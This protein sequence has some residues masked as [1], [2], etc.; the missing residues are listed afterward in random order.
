MPLDPLTVGS[1][2][3]VLGARFAGADVTAGGLL[4]NIATN[5]VHP[6][7]ESFRNQILSWFNGPH[8]D[9]NMD[10]ERAVAR[11][12]IHADLFCIIEALHE[13]LDPPKSAAAWMERLWERCPEGIR[14]L[15]PSFAG[16]FSAAEH[17]QLAQIK[18][19]CLRRLQEVESSTFQPLPPDAF[20][21]HL[22]RNENYQRQLTQAAVRA[23]EQDY[24]KLPEA[25][26]QIFGTKWFAY[27]C[28]SFSYEIKH[29]QP[30]SNIY[31][32]IAAD[33]LKRLVR[34]EGRKTRAQVTQE[35]QKTRAAL[36]GAVDSL[37]QEIRKLQSAE[38]V[39]DPAAQA[40]ELVRVLEEET[41]RILED[42]ESR[43]GRSFKTWR[44]FLDFF[45]PV[46]VSR[47]MLRPDDNGSQNGNQGTKLEWED[48]RKNL[49]RA[50]VLGN[51][52]FGKT[53]LLWYE[54][55]RRNQEWLQR[56]QNGSAAV[57]QADV[58]LFI[59]ALELASG[60][61]GSAGSEIMDVLMARVSSRI[62]LSPPVASLIREK[63]ARG[64]G[65]IAI[66]ALDETPEDLRA[67]LKTKLAD[68]SRKYP[69]ARLLLSSRWLGYSRAP[70]LAGAREELEVLPFSHEQMELAVKRWFVEDSRTAA[71]VWQ[72]IQSQQSICEEL[73]SPLLLRLA[74]AATDDKRR[75]NEKLLTWETRGELY[76]E[77]IGEAAHLW[78]QRT[79]VKEKASLREAEFL[80]PDCAAELALELWKT[81]PRRTLW[82]QAEVARHLHR[83]RM[84]ERSFH[85]RSDLLGDLC[86]AGILAL[87]GTEDR[88][89][90]VMFTHRSL[91]EYLAARALAGLLENGTTAEW[92]L[93]DRK[94]WDPE[95][96]EVL[97]LVT[98]QLTPEATERYLAVFANE[99]A[100]DEIRHRL[101]LAARCVAEIPASMRKRL[102]AL[103]DSITTSVFRFYEAAPIPAMFWYVDSFRRIAA[104]LNGAPAPP[105]H[106]LLA[107]VTRAFRALAPINGRVGSQSLSQAVVESST[108]KELIGIFGDAAPRLSL[109]SKLVELLHNPESSVRLNALGWLQE[110][111]PKASSHS[112]VIDAV[113]Q[114]LS[115]AN[116]QIQNEAAETLSTFDAAAANFPG[117][118]DMLLDLADQE[119]DEVAR[120]AE[121]AWIELVS[122]SS[123]LPAVVNSLLDLLQD[124]DYWVRY[125]AVDRLGG[126]AKREHSVARQFR[127]IN[128]LVELLHDPHRFVRDRTVSVLGYFGKAAIERREDVS[129]L[130]NRV[131]QSFRDQDADA[132]G[133]AVEVLRT[134]GVEAAR[135]AGVLD[136]LCG[137]LADPDEG[138]RLVAAGTLGTMGEAVAERPDIVERLM[139][140]LRST[141]PPARLC[142][143]EA[144]DENRA[145]L[146]GYPAVLESSVALLK[147]SEPEVRRRAATVLAKASGLLVQRTDLVLEM[148]RILAET[149]RMLEPN[150][151][152]D[153]FTSTVLANDSLCRLIGAVA[154]HPEVVAR[155]REQQHSPDNFIRHGVVQVLESLPEAIVSRP[156]VRLLLLNA[157]DDSDRLI[158]HKAVMICQSR[159]SALAWPE[160]TTRL[161]A[162][163][164]DTDID[165]LQ[166]V[167]KAFKNMGPALANSPEVIDGLAELLDRSRPDVKREVS[168]ILG[169]ISPT[170]A[171][172]RALA[173]RF[174]ALM[175][176][177]DG[178][179]RCAAVRATGTRGLAAD[180]PSLLHTLVDLLSDPEDGVSWA[181]AEVLWNVGPALGEHASVIERLMTLFDHASEELRLR[182]VHALGNL[183]SACEAAPALVPRL[184]TLL[185]DP[186]ES[187]RREALETL[188]L[189]PIPKSEERAA[190]DGLVELLHHSDED[191]REKAAEILGSMAEPVSR[192]QEFV[193][194]LFEQAADSDIEQTIASMDALA[195]LVDGGIRFWW[196]EDH[197]IVKTVRELSAE[198]PAIVD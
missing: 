35:H 143:L 133:K 168:V 134:I 62:S 96:E 86:S 42:A 188:S 192:Y 88:R 89:T 25:A 24:G 174:N 155:L 37:S 103:I 26:R 82:D 182:A 198:N 138:V 34:H 185:H 173:A 150:A 6:D 8:Y 121:A 48:A 104:T 115:D 50:V 141:E 156:D 139:D 167:L 28:N 126:I 45:V 195:A 58:A 52:G 129:V 68:F 51:P 98:G 1:I 117:L 21:L 92:A 163:A 9:K 46:R 47:G 184:V 142:A 116:P 151:G 187:V 63:L 112:E 118:L 100:D 148:L 4:A 54:A 157:M 107:H 147:D 29:N 158:K 191:I 106:A 102:A 122:V 175:R 176:D 136:E 131:A 81:D 91:G 49:Q 190:L 181:A 113:M 160:I 132:R 15:R 67:I 154:Q 12:S 166:M 14:N 7:V 78:R 193:S 10:L 152:S 13:P 159:G 79:E 125:S 144:L 169:N 56:M 170:G 33:R 94:A 61:E 127:I 95:W 110:M 172:R 197:H 153:R 109:T 120:A 27:L 38:P 177:A 93:I 57:G 59:R 119:D 20:R 60:L 40:Q 140:L 183:G 69:R 19:G 165:L 90:P 70:L 149:P 145:V 161:F 73:Q 77:F 114:L 16:I 135:H 11:S 111:G 43:I 18:S 179:V 84:R 39:V 130:A 105:T 75:R 41:A 162:L 178:T 71:L 124:P 76:A 137:L 17:A 72:H 85:Q 146:S 44:S 189:A 30:V 101:A 97:V 128:A 36:A 3:A 5:V 23:L 180:E 65:L 2:L 22:G 83:I 108:F 186:S 194:R 66:D 123:Q 64:E 171:R 53:T 74:C 87:A 55:G 31:Q 32:R 164:N 99:A 196:K 80:L